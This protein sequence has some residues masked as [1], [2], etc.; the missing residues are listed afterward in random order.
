MATKPVSVRISAEGGAQVRAELLEVGA[1]GEQM[2]A[3][4]TRGARTGGGGLANLGF[5]VQDFAVQVGAGTSAT[6]ALAQQLPQLLSGFGLLGVALGTTAAIAIPLAGYFF[7]MGEEA[8]AAADKVEALARKVERLSQVNENFSTEGIQR[9]IDKYGEA[10]AAVLLLISRQQ[11]LAEDQ[12]ISAARDVATGF[13]AEFEGLFAYLDEYDSRL[14]QIAQATGAT[15]AEAQSFGAIQESVRFLNEEFG[16]SIE[17]ARAI[18]DALAGLNAASGIA[19]TANAT[20]V[21]SGLL[22]G[23]SLAGS[24]LAD[25]LLRAEEALRRLNAEGSGIGGWLGAAIDGAAGLSAQLFEAARAALSIRQGFTPGTLDGGPDAARS[26]V[27]FGQA[28]FNGQV[29]T[30]RPTSAGLPTPVAP[31]SSGGGGGSRAQTDTLRE[32]ARIYESTRTEA[33]KYSAEVAKLDGLLKS[34]AITQDTYNRA[35]DDLKGGLSDAASYARSLENSFESAFTSFVTGASSAKEAAA[36]LLAQL[37]QLLAQS[38]FRQLLGG[39]GFFGA[40]GGFLAGGRAGGGPVQ[41]GRSYMVGESGPERVFMTGNGYVV[42]NNA[43]RGGG[44]GGGVNIT[45]NAPGAVEGTP[46]LIRRE[47]E[48]VVPEITRRSVAANLKAQQRG[49]A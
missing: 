39:G 14:Q 33:E 37:A 45:I 19:E 12:A 38:A 10:D 44:S 35:I 13:N 2:G 49:Y 46:A 25:Q 47:V 5:Q 16:V 32:A 6:Q 42:P 41:A 24:D 3:R 20:A 21:L 34:G 23:S 26:A 15:E 7:S 18:R 28:S 8:E 43:L 30:P 1:A 17:Q 9:L 27:Q 31:R 29:L 22:E 48:R 36:Q 40:V 4:L 11:K